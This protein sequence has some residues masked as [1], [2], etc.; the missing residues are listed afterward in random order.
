MVTPGAAPQV[1]DYALVV[2]ISRYSEPE[3]FPD[4]QGPDNDASA[5]RDWLIDEDGG[6]VPPG[7]VVV[8]RTADFESLSSDPQPASA[9]IRQELVS[10]ARR[11]KK[12][13]GRRLYLYF[14]GHGFAPKLEEAAVFTADAT[15]EEFA[16][17]YVHDYLRWFRTAQ[18]FQ[19]SVLWVDACMNFMQSVPPQPVPMGVQIGTA[20]PGP[21]FIALAAQTKRALEAEMVDGQV[22]GVFTWTLLEGLRGRA[23]NRRARVTGKSLESFLHNAMAEALPDGVRTSSAVDLH[24]FIRADEGLEFKRLHERPS[25]EVKL[26]IPAAAAGEELRIWSGSPHQ[27]ALTATLGGPEWSGGLVR[28]LYVAEVPAAGLRDGFQVTGAGPVE[29]TIDRRGPAVEPAAGSELFDLEVTTSN[30]ATTVV[31]IDDEFG[32]VASGTGGLRGRES[33]GVYKLRAQIGRDMTTSS[34]EVV[35]L[36]RDLVLD[37]MGLVPVLE[38]PAPLDAGVPVN[39]HHAELFREAA[40]PMRPSGDGAQTPAASISVMVRYWA[41]VS[42]QANLPHPMK[43]L[44]YVAAEGATVTDLAERSEV[45]DERDDPIAVWQQPVDPGTH[46][47][48][49]EL[50]RATYEAAFTVSPGWLTQVVLR[51][52]AGLGG[53]WRDEDRPT[54]GDVLEPDD[55]ALFMRKEKLST[56]GSGD[57]VLEAAR[58]ALVHGRNVFSGGQGEVL[59]RVLLEEHPDP[60]ATIIGCHLLL[61]TISQERWTGVPLGDVY[62]TAVLRLRDLLGRNHPDVEALSLRCNDGRLRAT[63]PFTAPPSFTASWQL[64]VEASYDR[65][66]LVSQQVWERVHASTRLGPFLVWAVDDATKSAHAAQ[67]QAWLDGYKRAGRQRPTP[68]REAQPAAVGAQAEF[69]APTFSLQTGFLPAPRDARSV[70]LKVRDAARRL[71]IPATAAAH[72]WRGHGEGG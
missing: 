47:L 52:T 38:S 15:R 54:S 57:D 63:D 55:L 36:D 17:V 51:R 69:P 10:L 53:A 29:A 32:W 12:R 27:R 24:P 59:R 39:Q 28:G 45:Q 49:Q 44:G 61:R 62:D 72:L 42:E 40:D 6:H 58:L 22:H 11:T 34:E 18:R 9:R 8:L 41:P 68:A 23:A 65:P 19:E 37:G 14:S 64:I 33:P 16:H 7:N 46:F 25:L 67:L 50:D 35:L 2:G 43:G 4:L 20:V 3:F 26:H 5:V 60:I 56:G 70:P 71:G 30:P 13:P 31:V 1:D 66:D 48:R 21:A